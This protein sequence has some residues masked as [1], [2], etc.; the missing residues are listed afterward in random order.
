M[1]H[2]VLLAKFSKVNFFHNVIETM[3]SYLEGR[4]QRAMIN[5]DCHQPFVVSGNH[6]DKFWGYCYNDYE[7]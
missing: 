4:A 1:V 5:S 2:F 6:R 7:F 3:Q